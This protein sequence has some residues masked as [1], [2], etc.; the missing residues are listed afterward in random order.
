MSSF[1]DL[2]AGP[3]PT[4]LPADPADADSIARIAQEVGVPVTGIGF[5]AP[6]SGVRVAD[7][8]GRDI[9]LQAPGYRHF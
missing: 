3:P 6:G 9:V 7:A 4:Q 8:G 5:I 2:M 1:Q